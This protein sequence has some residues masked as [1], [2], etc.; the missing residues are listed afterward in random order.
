[1]PLI[2][3]DRVKDTTTSTSTGS[4]TLLG[5]AS[6]FQ[7]FSAGIGNGNTCY[8]TIALPGSSEWEVG[9]GTYTS[10]GNTLSRDTVLSSSNSGSLVSFS[11][12]TKDV[13]VTYPA[14]RSAL[15]GGSQA[16]ITNNTT[17][18]T[19][20]TL[21][22]GQNAMSVGPITIASGHAVTVSSGQRW[23]VI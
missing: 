16:I 6:G 20:Y 12:G 21:P 4:V 11:A 13:F 3:A 23:V 8:Y 18:N 7:T 2:Q 19:S 5:A 22:S 9:I 10:S 17:V 1:M 15:G 14:A